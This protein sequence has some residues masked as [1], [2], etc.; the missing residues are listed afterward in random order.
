MAATAMV[1]AFAACGGDDEPT[2]R[3]TR[4]ATRVGEALG[5]LEVALGARDHRRICEQL[6]SE[7]LRERLGGRR[8]P[9]A[10][11]RALRGLREPSITI[12]AISLQGAR[13]ARARVVTQAASQAPARDVV[14]F[15]LERGG[16]RVDG[17]GAM[18]ES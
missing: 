4:D 6:F 9:A 10:L 8:C 17:L 12:E 7:A 5:R 11:R 15:V 16:F 1:L 3:V 14:E 13:R 18:P 2:T